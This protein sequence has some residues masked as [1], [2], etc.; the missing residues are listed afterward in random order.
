MMLLLSHEHSHDLHSLGEY[1]GHE[2]P[3]QCGKEHE[4]LPRH[5]LLVAGIVIEPWTHDLQSLSEEMGLEQPNQYGKEYETLRRVG[6]IVV[7]PCTLY[8]MQLL[9]KK[10]DSDNLTNMGRNMKPSDE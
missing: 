8:Y 3:N 4:T 9:G 10:W 7:K 2:H 6:G 1:M 5:H